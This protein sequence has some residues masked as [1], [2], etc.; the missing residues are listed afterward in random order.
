MIGVSVANFIVA[1]GGS[2]MELFWTTDAWVEVS[3]SVIFLA[4]FFYLIGSASTQLLKSE[5]RYLIH[6]KSTWLGTFLSFFFLFVGMFL[7]RRRIEKIK[8]RIR[9]KGGSV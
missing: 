5:K 3:I 8:A 4:T 9:I 1:S 6:T 2:A 7:L